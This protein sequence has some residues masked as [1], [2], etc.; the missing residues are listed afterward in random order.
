MTTTTRRRQPL[1]AS[2]RPAAA[3]QLKRLV[4]QVLLLLRQVPPAPAP[5]VLAAE[6]EA[7]QL[8]HQRQQM[9][10]RVSV[11]VQVLHQLQQCWSPAG[12]AGRAHVATAQRQQHLSHQQ[13]AQARAVLLACNLPMLRLGQGTPHCP[14]FRRRK[15]L[16]EPPE[17][18]AALPRCEAAAA[19]VSEPRVAACI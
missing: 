9:Q 15:H 1:L 3:A 4:A 14:P 2:D 18:Q 16:M 13:R 12:G 10:P 8:Q 7:A 11:L 17:A 19:A 5:A 6:V